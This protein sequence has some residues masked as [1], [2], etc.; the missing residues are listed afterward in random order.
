MFRDM[1]GSSDRDDTTEFLKEIQTHFKPQPGLNACY[2]FVI[3]GKKTPLIIEIKG[4]DL[5]CYYG[6]ANQVNVEVQLAREILENIIAGKTTFQ[7]SF[8]AGDMRMKG[9]F[10]ILR[11]L[12]Q[13]LTFAAK[14]GE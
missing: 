12:D 5:Q 9:D 8:M 1:M 10:K 11:A 6:S 2:K 13:V 7:T 14:K 3:E 4:G